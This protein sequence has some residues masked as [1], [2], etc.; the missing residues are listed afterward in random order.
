MKS[1]SQAR[2]DLWALEYLG[3]PETG[4][5]LD[6]GAMDGITSSNSYL[7]EKELKW[8]GL[9]VECHPVHLPEIKKNRDC[10]IVER[11]LYDNNGTMSFRYDKSTVTSKFVQNGTFVKCI[12]F[13]KL[14]KDYKVPNVIDYMS[15]DIEG[16]E[17]VSLLKFP[18]DTHTVKLMTVEHNS[19]LDGPAMKN[20]IKTLLESKGYFLAEEDV[21]CSDSNNLPF[22]D[23]YIHHKY[24]K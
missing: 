12:T 5:Y 10:T 24:V 17:Y 13:D 7:M 22:E 1:Y 16:A 19:Y 2:Q 4:Y 15:I 8:D 23:W 20:D 21:A 3:F 11:A 9:C 18:F 14:F 6:I